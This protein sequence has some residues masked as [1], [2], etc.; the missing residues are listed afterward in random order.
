MTWQRWVHIIQNDV[1]KRN[2]VLSKENYIFSK[3]NLVLSKKN[4]SLSKKNFSFKK[5]PENDFLDYFRMVFNRT[6]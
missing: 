3:K 5:E 6:K 1:S 4:F 2:F